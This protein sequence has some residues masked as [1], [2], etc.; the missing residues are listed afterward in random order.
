LT[1]SKDQ[2]GDPLLGTTPAPAVQPTAPA[3]Q[4]G[5][6]PPIPH[7][8][9]LTTNAALASQTPTGQTLA[10]TNTD[11]WARKIDSQA[12]P[13]NRTPATPTSLP[14]VQAI[15]KDDS[16]TRASIQPTSWSA[17][18]QPPTTPTNDQL[19][20]QLTD[21][22]VIGHN[23]ENVAGGVR[24]TCVVRSPSNPNTVQ[25]YYTT[26]VDYPTAVQAILH[27]IEAQKAQP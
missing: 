9:G 17:G 7:N 16:P 13:A 15:P 8:T 20:Q 5:G 4:T 27:E 25:N 6:L 24:L 10:I 14:K 3:T 11:G 19:D 26:A 18:S 2:L 12:P 23:Q 22:G 21:H 1:A